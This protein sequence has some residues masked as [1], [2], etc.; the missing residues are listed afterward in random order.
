MALVG[1]LMSAGCALQTGDPSVD[2]T[3]RPGELVS[4]Q[5]GGP[6]V[7][8]AENANA[9]LDRPST[10]APTGDQA[11]RGAPTAPAGTGAIGTGPK[12]NPNP[13]PWGDGVNGP[14][15]LGPGTGK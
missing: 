12:D 13:S 6:G 7:A 5:G 14:I 4:E 1:A 9:M 10:V 11:S 3:Q 8:H 15:E 2:E